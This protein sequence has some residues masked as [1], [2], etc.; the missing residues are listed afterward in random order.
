MHTPKIQKSTSSNSHTLKPFFNKSGGDGFFVQPKESQKPFF[1]SHPVQAKS[2]TGEKAIA[3]NSHASRPF[4]SASNFLSP[5]NT[6]QLQAAPGNQKAA[7][8][9]LAIAVN[10][11]ANMPKVPKP[12]SKPINDLGAWEMANMIL[13]PSIIPQIE[14]ANPSKDNSSYL[15]S[16]TIDLKPAY[17]YFIGTELIDLAKDGYTLVNPSGI[18]LPA[19]PDFKQMKRC[20]G[21]VLSR[22]KRHA[23]KHF[24][25]YKTE[26]AA[27]Q[28]QFTNS[29]QQLPSS[30]NPY[31]MKRAEL[32]AHVIH[33][34]SYQMDLLKRQLWQLTCDLEKK[35]YPKLLKKTCVH[36]QLKVACGTKPK[37][38]NP[39]PLLIKATPKTKKTKK[40]PKKVE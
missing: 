23:L 8:V 18:K 13:H 11:S 32:E 20:F 37:L 12:V 40:K 28:S 14:S 30:G 4:F 2:T 36:G 38:Q 3:K 33:F 1:S 21:T 10:W 25:I 24:K 34:V 5:A 35:D 27:F 22:I 15:K 17:E 29:L 16:L 31:P 19:S 9:A 7:P 39:P 6:I 26:I